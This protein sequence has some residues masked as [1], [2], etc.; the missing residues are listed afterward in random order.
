MKYEPNKIYHV[1]N[2][3][4]NRQKIFFSEANYEFFIWKIKRQILP[5][6]DLLAFCLMPNHF[7]LL[8][9]TKKEACLPSNWVKPRPKSLVLDD[10]DIKMEDAE[11]YMQKLSKSLAIL[12]RSYTRA[13]NI[14]EKRTGSLFRM[15]VK[16]K[17]A[18]W[19]SDIAVNEQNNYPKICFNYIHENPV[20]S[21][22]VD[23][24][25]QW[26]YSSAKAYW[27]LKIK[28]ICNKE[29]AARLELFDGML[30]AY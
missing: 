12:Q 11:N 5:L 29:L 2:Q 10:P 16:S 14:Q 20:K 4:N 15:N 25:D 22:L 26:P 8:I 3:G 17:M 18:D 13:I 9:Y 27:N 28:S 30:A 21:G 7:H 1:F 19:H 6:A 24:A 23:R